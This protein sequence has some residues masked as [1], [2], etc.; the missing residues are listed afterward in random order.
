MTGSPGGATP[1]R[2]AKVMEG[3]LIP[4]PP[5]FHRSVSMPN[6]AQ[7]HLCPGSLHRRLF[8]G[9]VALAVVPALLCSIGA[10]AAR[11]ATTANTTTPGVLSVGTTFLCAGFEWAITGDDNDNCAVTLQYR[12]AG[13]TDWLSAQPLLRVEHGLWTHGE[14]S[15]NLLAGSLF[16]LEPGTAYE[17]RLTLA[18]P[19]G[20]AEQRV[21]AFTTRPV[22]QAVA[23][24]TKYVIPG[25]GGGTGSV[26]DP[27]RGLAAA[28]AA[29]LP[30][31]LVLLQPGTYH[32]TFTVTR[33]GTLAAP[34]VYRGTDAATVILDGDGGTAS[35]SQCVRLVA[36]QYVFVE[37]LT[38]V[39]CLRP[40]NADSSVGVVV[41]GCT[42]RPIVQLLSTQGIRAAVSR[43]LV[44]TDNR[45][46]M[47]GQW[48]TIGRTGTYGTGGYGIL[49]EGTGLVIAHN[50]IIEA[51]DAISIPV[52]GTAIPATVTSNVDIY[53]NFVDRASDDAIQADATQHNVR[54]FHNRLLNS[55]S[56]VSFQP[57]FGGPGYMLFNEI[58]NSR[59]E[60][61]KFHQETSYGWTQETSGFVVLHNTSV[62]S[63]DAWYES[64]IWRHGTFRDNLMLGARPGTYS[65]Q[66]GYALVGASFDYDGWNRVGGFATLIRLAGTSY[67]TLPTFYAGTGNEHHGIEVGYSDL[68]KAPVP[69]DP[70]W[71][72]PDGYGWA[73]VPG[74]IDLRLASN[75]TAIDKGGLLANVNDSYRGAAP[76]LGCAEAGDPA[77]QYGPHA[78]NQPP[79][80]F[81]SSDLVTGYGPLTVHFVG[82][83]TDVDGL[84]VGW[85]WDFGDGATVMGVRRPTH[86]F[87][88]PGRY[89]ALLTVTD[90][91]GATANVS[92]AVNVTGALDVAA[93]VV[94]RARLW[95][96][97]PSPFELSTTIVF[98]LPSRSAVSLRIHDVRGAL[99]R[100]LA[101]GE[102]E[103][104]EHA[105]VWDGLG[106]D[107]RP[108]QPG[109]YF[110]RLVVP[111]TV[112]GTRL[113]RMR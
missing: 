88:V 40:V 12:R 76:D 89:S 34:I 106:D 58:F 54:I 109:I 49:V 37:K 50:T 22:P 44:V 29:A 71:N 31:D 100:T 65:F 7:I 48:A 9:L 24:R 99:V 19:D 2:V 17:A 26:T 96:A 15:S 28:N 105:V 73:Y 108:A 94:P 57:A 52:T 43:D 97:R 79:T 36:R 68:V 1:L 102:L 55:G 21:V 62:C 47:P 32:G 92:V 11:A 41:R 110:C 4:L 107:G 42:I 64:G 14:D 60:S 93:G 83:A 46:E 101:G 82:D 10:P 16:F 72:S 98:A 86:V 6:L 18:D 66:T 80:A 51:W 67:A 8:H 95:P 63:R 104:G 84:V 77:R 5:V 70:L 103:A 56:A 33:N 38:M 74:D 59:I 13:T 61:W 20:G 27:Y 3:V 78:V 23:L 111:G 39:N 91:D 45:I 30:G 85:R 69:D 90:E 113:L 35:N 25:T 87:T 53:E 112:L 81:A 75:S